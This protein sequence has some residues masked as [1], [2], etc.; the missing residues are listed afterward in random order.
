MPERVVIAGAAGVMADGPFLAR[1]AEVMADPGAP[2]RRA[3]PARP[4]TSC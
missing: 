2:P 1:V 3:A 4:P